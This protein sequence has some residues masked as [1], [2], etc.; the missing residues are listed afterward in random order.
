MNASTPHPRASSNRRSALTGAPA[1]ASQ[2]PAAIRQTAV[3][4]PVYL[5]AAASPMPIP[6]S[7]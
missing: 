6:A 4:A 7:T 1:A 2:M 3:I 5:V